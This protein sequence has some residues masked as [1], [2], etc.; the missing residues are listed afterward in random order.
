[1]VRQR[2][3]SKLFALNVVNDAERK[4]PKRKVSPI[5]PLARAQLG[6]LA[7]EGKHSFEL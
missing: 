3:D 4:L 6:M 1:M 7:Y 2:D 5:V